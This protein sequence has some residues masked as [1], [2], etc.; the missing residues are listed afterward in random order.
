[1]KLLQNEVDFYD[2]MFHCLIEVSGHNNVDT[3]VKRY[4]EVEDKNFALFN[5]VNN[6]TMDKKQCEADIEALKLEIV[7][8]RNLNSN[9]TTERKKIMAELEGKFKIVS[10][11]RI[12]NDK[13]DKKARKLLEGVKLKILG[14]FNKIGC[15]MESMSSM[16]GN[17]EITEENITQILGVVERRANEI[18]QLKLLLAIKEA[19]ESEITPLH[20]AWT[21][22]HPRALKT[23][24]VPMSVR[25]NNSV[26][27]QR[28]EILHDDEAAPASP[29]SM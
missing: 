12:L 7:T 19:K 25:S 29:A 10:R 13:E 3:M 17:T 5:F 23:P 27:S 14:T 2:E 9:M 1:M 22:H 26:G 15:D 20:A 28:A 11:E 8:L 4:I 21:G 18:I 16:L 6:Q 24:N